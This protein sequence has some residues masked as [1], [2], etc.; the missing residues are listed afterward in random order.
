MTNKINDILDTDPRKRLRFVDRILPEKRYKA[1]SSL[2]K[3][4]YVL[5]PS[6][7]PESLLAESWADPH[8]TAAHKA[9]MRACIYSNLISSVRRADE[10]SK[11]EVNAQR[12]TL[13][14]HGSLGNICVYIQ[15]PPAQ[16]E[17]CSRSFAE[18]FEK[19]RL[20]VARLHPSAT[21]TIRS[22][23]EKLDQMK[24]VIREMRGTKINVSLF[25][26]EDEYS[27]TLDRAVFD[28]GKVRTR[29][30]EPFEF[31]V[32]RFSDGSE[33]PVVRPLPRRE[34]TPEELRQIDQEIAE[35]LDE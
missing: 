11:P 2:E 23:P 3:C 15:A 17:E 30:D 33:R 34:L 29:P 35:L 1:F 9:I 19:M 4:S 10:M 7:S 28:E 18:L 6:R 8:V 26:N 27:L 12:R 24:G 22:K 20:L 5:S 21:I 32:E 25:N 16:S 31:W 14:H 13:T